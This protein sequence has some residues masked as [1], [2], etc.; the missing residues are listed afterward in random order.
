M[1]ENRYSLWCSDHGAFLSSD[2]SA[3]CPR[4]SREANVLPP[5]STIERKLNL[6]DGM[7]SIHGP[8]LY[9]PAIHTGA[10]PG[11]DNALH[12]GESD[13]ALH[14]IAQ[15][16]TDDSGASHVESPPKR[17]SDAKLAP[18]RE[19]LPDDR[20]S[21]TRRFRLRYTHKDGTP[22]TMRLYFTA[23]LYPDGRV[24][25]VFVKAD[26]TGTL[27]SGSMDCVAVMMSM[28]LQY[29]VPLEEVCKKLRH[30][31]FGPGGWTG[32]A[33]FPSCSSPLDLLAQWLMKKWG[34]KLS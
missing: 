32:D 7:C 25:E 9:D 11:C 23:G 31:R 13:D 18:V 24:G 6:R 21:S 4:C 22:D 2:P 33:E 20:T 26:K 10:C 27:A 15:A 30:T 19:R 29:G 1:S 16:T 28:M 17:A 12:Q 3:K 14:Q 5:A 34:P 8:Y